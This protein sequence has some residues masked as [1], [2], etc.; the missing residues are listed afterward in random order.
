MNPETALSLHILAEV[1]SSP[2]HRLWRNARGIYYAGSIVRRLP[3]GDIVLRGC[4][5][6]S[7]GLC[8]GAADLVG[9]VSVPVRCL[10]PEGV[11]GL[12]LGIE[13]KTPKAVRRRPGVVKPHQTAWLEVVRSLGGIAGVARSVEEAR[14]IL[15]AE[16]GR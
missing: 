14:G 6:V 9:L 10:D 8:D 4:T 7:A 12:F 1:G 3:N 11:A 13:V 15:A 2:T 5:Q 16:G